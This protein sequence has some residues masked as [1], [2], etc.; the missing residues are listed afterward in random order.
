[1]RTDR[2]FRLLAAASLVAG[3]VAMPTA[4]LAHPQGLTPFDYVPR[5]VSDVPVI[6]DVDDLGVDIVRQT[7]NVEFVAHVPVAPTSDMQFQRREGRQMLKGELIDDTRDILVMGGTQRPG[8]AT[9]D[10]TDPENPELL[11]TVSC[12]GFHSDVAVYENYA[13]QAWDGTTRPCEAGD[14]ANRNGVENALNSGS[15]GIR[16]YD[17]TDP[18]DPVMVARYGT[19]DGIPKG[20]HNITVNG[21]AGLVYLDMAELDP[22]NPKWGYIDLTDP[23]LPVT[24]M[25]IRDISP[26]AGDGCHDGGI[27]PERELFACPGIT[28]SYIW[29]ISDPRMPVEVA[30][31]PNPAISI[32]H[33]ARWTPDEQTLVLGDELAG[34]AA[35]TPCS[36]GSNTLTP[37]GAAWFYN[38][39]IAEAPVLSGVFSTPDTDGDYCTTHFYGFQRNTTLMPMGMYDAGIEVVDYAAVADGLPGVPT[40]HAVF[41][42][43]E[44]GFFSA[45][46]WHGYVYG[47]S[48]E[49]G[50]SGKNLEADGRGLWIIKVDGIEDEEPVATDE[51]SVWGRWTPATSGV[52]VTMAARIGLAPAEAHTNAPL[53]ALAGALVLLSAGAVRRRRAVEA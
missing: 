20:V 39:S 19:R 30:H 24:M 22:V 29:D 4:A 41:E 33:G 25:D 52:H 51:G 18:A 45:Y 27:A 34:A 10:V 2:P 38:A 11:A 6:T 7:D 17:I 1:M 47:S 44:A 32:H 3:M 23:A 46:A 21:D 37:T 53:Y 12:G 9:F 26:T 43:D 42:P 28:A 31:I 15:D 36:G 40:Q 35:A 16:I 13:I 8:M 50:A 5:D 49:Y 14:P 48:F